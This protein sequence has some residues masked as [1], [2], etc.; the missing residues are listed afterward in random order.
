[1]SKIKF[2]KPHSLIYMHLKKAGYIRSP[3][4]CV[5]SSDIEP[6]GGVAQCHGKGRETSLCIYFDDVGKKNKKNINIKFDKKCVNKH[7]HVRF[8]KKK[9]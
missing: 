9:E 1:M 7:L 5:K 6:S 2:Q 8:E 4:L 3:V